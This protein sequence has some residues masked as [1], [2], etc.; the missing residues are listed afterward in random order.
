[1]FKKKMEISNC[2]VCGYGPLSEPYKSSQE[3]RRSYDI[4][5]CCGCEYGYD[6]DESFYNEWVNNGCNWFDKKEKPKEWVLESQI[7]NQIRPWPPENN[8]KT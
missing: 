7:K 4:C 8:E 3:L 5:S 1:M 2:P 6:D